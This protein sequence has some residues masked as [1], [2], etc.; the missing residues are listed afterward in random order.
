[1]DLGSLNSP[2]VRKDWRE[3]LKSSWMLPFVSIAIMALVVAHRTWPVPLPILGGTYFI[4]LALTFLVR[5]YVRHTPIENTDSITCERII[6]M[7]SALGIAGV[8]IVSHVL[9]SNPP[10]GMGFILI[11]PLCAQA[12]LVSALLGPTFAMFSLTVVAF[13]LGVGDA[14]PKE[15]LATAWISG[16]VGA[17]AVNPLRQRSDL[18]RAV[19]I[20]AL[21]LAL[22][23]ASSTMMSVNQ[24]MPVLASAG[25]A[26]V[27]AIVATAIFWFAVVA[28]ERIFGIISDWSLL[29]IC[30]PENPLIRELCLRAPGTYAH[31][32]MVANL[33]EQAARAIGANPIHVRAM[34]YFHDI[35]KIERP[36]YFI[37]NQM[38]ENLH[39][40]L[41]PTMSARIIT[42]HVKDGLELAK[43][44]RLPRIIQDGIAEHHGTSLVSYFYNRALDLSGDNA[45]SGLDRL[46]RYDGPKPQNRETAVL[47]LADQVEAASRSLK[48]GNSEELEIMISKIIEN[49]RADGQLDECDLSFKDLFK[50]RDA[51]MHSLSAIRHDRVTYPESE[52]GNTNPQNFGVERDDHESTEKTRPAGLD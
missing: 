32:V 29:E 34:A 42:A 37:E 6:W 45:T 15:L 16:S 4:A 49:S 11:G 52:N 24:V 35:G 33:A 38:G 44:H 46:F 19:S 7:V 18:M 12:M 1:M 36:M 25:W 8:Q 40:D 3:I 47:H 31:S 39:D 23:A 17:Q 14:I 51:F 13:L 10:D 41:P 22:I 27:S 9:G 48:R 5:Y 21:A 26:A 28:L 50:I 43:R 30:S 20:T 2:Q